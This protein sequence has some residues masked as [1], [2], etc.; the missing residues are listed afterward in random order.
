MKRRWLLLGLGLI[1]SLLFLW[2]AWLA[3]RELELTEI[4]KSCDPDTG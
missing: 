2:F 1:V 4:D 3:V